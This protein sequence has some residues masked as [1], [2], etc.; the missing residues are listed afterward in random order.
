MAVALDKRRN[1]TGQTS[2][3]TRGRITIP[4]ELRRKLGLRPGGILLVSE[5]KG[6]LV[7]TPLRGK[8]KRKAPT[9]RSLATGS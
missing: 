5:R 9:S 7:F 8:S 4:A 3:T 2:F 1:Q 6:S